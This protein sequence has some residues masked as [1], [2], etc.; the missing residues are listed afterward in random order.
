[1]SH[2]LDREVEF[3]VTWCGRRGKGRSMVG[4][5]SARGRLWVCLR[6]QHEPHHPCVTNLRF[7]HCSPMSQSEILVQQ[8][9]AFVAPHSPEQQNA[10]LPPV[11]AAS[12]RSLRIYRGVPRPPKAACEFVGPDSQRQGLS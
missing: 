1:M 12:A 5:G 7:S 8:V 2:W 4:H 9:A 11:K 3:S 6:S 10:G